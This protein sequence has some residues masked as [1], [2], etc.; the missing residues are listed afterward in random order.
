MSTSIPMFDLTP[1]TSRKVKQQSRTIVI[2]RMEVN[3]R[4][5]VVMVTSAVP[6]LM[7]AGALWPLLREF[8]LIA[9]PVAMFAGWWLFYR[10]AKSGLRL[11]TVQTIRD[12]V[13]ARNG[14]LYFAGRAV[15]AEP[16]ELRILF[17]SSIPRIEW[18]DASHPGADPDEA[19]AGLFEP[20]TLAEPPPLEVPA[21]SAHVADP[22]STV[23]ALDDFD[24]YPLE[25]PVWGWD[26]A[27]DHAPG[28]P[29]ELSAPKGVR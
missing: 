26:A 29:L 10:R 16:A 5:A 2:Q 1:F 17:R 20:F 9:L 14:E 8:A 4:L 28:A 13:Q 27:S 24:N 11:R 22:D 6:G 3:Y 25:V 12:R 15:D 18:D 21:W 19:V 7:V 23:D